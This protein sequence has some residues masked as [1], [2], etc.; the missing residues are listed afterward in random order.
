MQHGRFFPSKNMVNINIKI[1]DELHRD[2]KLEA[3]KRNTTIKE[4]IITILENIK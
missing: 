4:L 3:V 2:L 1:P